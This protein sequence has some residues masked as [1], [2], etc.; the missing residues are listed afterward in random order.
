MKNQKNK[1]YT[2]TLIELLVVIAIIAILASMLLPAL[3]KARDKAKQITCISNHKQIGTAHNLYIGDY[4]GFTGS[5]VENPPGGTT[6]RK[7]WIN[8]LFPYAGNNESVFE[9]PST[10]SY[11]GARFRFS[12]VG[13]IAGYAAN[14]T[15]VT[16]SGRFN[17]AGTTHLYGH[18]KLTRLESP[19][20]TAVFACTKRIRSDG[21]IYT[22]TYWRQTGVLDGIEPVHLSR[23][24]N[25]TFYDGHAAPQ[26][27][28]E[29]I[30]FIANAEK[31]TL[32]FAGKWH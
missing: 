21:K 22:E 1:K 3:N 5:Y 8:M 24:T 18:R 20:Q 29:L 12:G 15:S 31:R 9:C 14:I 27:R 26:T 32:F 4:D 16:G 19:S 7:S 6:S 23:I 25:F 17:A 28:N 13:I 30:S 2:F 10:I 11:P